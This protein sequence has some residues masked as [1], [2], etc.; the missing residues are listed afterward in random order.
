LDAF[1][2]SA[3]ERKPPVVSGEDG[4]RALALAHRILEGM[5]GATTKDRGLP[6]QRGEI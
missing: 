4:K 5:E 3:R 2:E 1:V 6:S